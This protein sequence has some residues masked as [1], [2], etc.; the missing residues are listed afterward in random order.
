M[1]KR[2]RANARVTLNTQRE[3]ERDTHRR[4]RCCVHCLRGRSFWPRQ[5]AWRRRR[6]RGAYGDIMP[7]SLLEISRAYFWRWL[8]HGPLFPASTAPAFLG[9]PLAA[10]PCRGTWFRLGRSSAAA[11]AFSSG[12]LLLPPPLCRPRIFGCCYC[13]SGLS[14]GLAGWLAGWLSD[15][16]HD[17]T[18]LARFR[19]E[20]RFSRSERPARVPG[21]CSTFRDRRGRILLPL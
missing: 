10:A 20:R 19:N 1:N 6:V 17:A 3:R 2:E 12:S 9:G 16:L 21:R 7:L 5:H 15:S 13:L 4:C 18:H 11:P 8:G 14:A